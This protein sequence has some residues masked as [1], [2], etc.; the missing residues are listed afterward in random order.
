MPDQPY[1]NGSSVIHTKDRWTLSSDGRFLS[2]ES[3]DP[4]TILIYDRQ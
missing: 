3:D 2:V 4:K 1:V